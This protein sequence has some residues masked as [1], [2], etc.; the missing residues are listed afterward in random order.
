M[1][2][3]DREIASRVD[4]HH[5]QAA[6]DEYACRAGSAGGGRWRGA[7]LDHHAVPLAAAAE[8]REA[9]QRYFSCSCRSARIRWA[10]LEFSAPPSLLRTFTWLPSF[11]WRT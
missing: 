6:I 8:R 2:R 11:S 5:L 3:I 1:E 4:H 7:R 9:K 10:V